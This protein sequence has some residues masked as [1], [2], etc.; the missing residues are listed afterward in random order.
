MGRTQAEN[1]KAV[2]A[3]IKGHGNDGSIFPGELEARAYAESERVGGLVFTAA[4]WA[5]FVGGAR[6]GDFD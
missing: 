4:E 6:D 1:V 2:L 3:D 5:A